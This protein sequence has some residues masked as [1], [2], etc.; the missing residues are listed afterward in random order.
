M[1]VILKFRLSLGSQTEPQGLE[2]RL[3]PRAAEED[4]YLP[5][6]IL[7]PVSEFRSSHHWKREPNSNQ[8]FLH[9]KSLKKC[10]WCRLGQSSERAVC[11]SGLSLGSEV[12]L[13]REQERFLKLPGGEFFFASLLNNVG[14]A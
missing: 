6:S 1:K 13:E 8:F 10:T 5:A 11:V 12:K 2:G 7:S 14:V 3:Q 4:S 9:L